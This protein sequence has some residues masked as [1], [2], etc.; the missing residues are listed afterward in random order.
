LPEGAGA[1]FC[2][3]PLTAAV[4]ESIGQPHQPD[5]HGRHQQHGPEPGQDRGGG[6]LHDGT[7]KSAAARFGLAALTLQQVGY[8][9]MHISR[10]QRRALARMRAQLVEP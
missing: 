2:L 1:L 9:Q 6:V 7:S 10:L 5:Q 8:Y 3:G 4:G